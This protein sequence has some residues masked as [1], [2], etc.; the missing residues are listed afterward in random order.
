MT[1]LLPRLQALLSSW[2]G[3]EYFEHAW[4]KECGKWKCACYLRLKR[5]L[6]VRLSFASLYL[7]Y[8]KTRG[9]HSSVYTYTH[10]QSSICLQFGLKASQHFDLKDLL[11]RTAWLLETNSLNS[12]SFLTSKR[13]TQLDSILSNINLYLTKQTHT[14]CTNW[15]ILVNNR[16]IPYLLAVF[17][18][19]LFLWLLSLRESQINWTHVQNQTFM[20][21]VNK[22][23]SYYTK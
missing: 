23:H 1:R 14:Q 7:Q 21:R 22:F 15:L 10:K 20:F 2:C 6:Q 16:H 3:P 9:D 11:K 17:K 18:E 19:Q 13:T 5:L 12:W 4:I 8:T